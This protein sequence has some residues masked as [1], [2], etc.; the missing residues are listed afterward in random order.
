MVK[1]TI[2]NV[3]IEVEEGTSI[4]NAARQVGGD[5]VP[6]TVNFQELEVNV[7]HV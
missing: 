3:Q 1:V 5:I 6:P 7:V 2:D 4:L